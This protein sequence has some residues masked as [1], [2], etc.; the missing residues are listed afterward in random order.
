M[1]VFFKKLKARRDAVTEDIVRLLA[2][3]EERCCALS[4][5]ELLALSDEELLSKVW[6]R[7]RKFADGFATARRALDSME[8]ARRTFYIAYYYEQSVNAEGLCA[9]FANN[10]RESALF[11]REALERIGAVEHKALFEDFL[12]HNR[13]ATAELSAFA[14]GSSEEFKKMERKYPFDEFN[15]SFYALEPMTGQMAA[16][17]RENISVF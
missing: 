3:E 14:I 11:L 8:E 12:H 1:V 15:A 13:I 5:D 9:Y 10:G 6:I 2:E 4:D 16:Y 17:V 7:T